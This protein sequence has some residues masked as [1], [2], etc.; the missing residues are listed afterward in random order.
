VQIKNKIPNRTTNF[1][2]VL[3]LRFTIKNCL[4]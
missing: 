1:I 4:I 3:R 2:L